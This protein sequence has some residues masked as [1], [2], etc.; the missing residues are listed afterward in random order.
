M[1]YEYVY[2]IVGVMVRVPASS[3]V[4]CGFEPVR[5][6]PKT[7]KLVFVASPLSMQHKGERAKTDMLIQP[8][9]S[10]EMPVPSQGHYGFHSFPVVD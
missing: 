2:H 7:I 9:I 1:R 4:D 6:K 3:A 10:L 8:T 5:V